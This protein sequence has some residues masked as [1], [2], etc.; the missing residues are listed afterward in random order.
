MKNLLL[1]AAL[2]LMSSFGFTQGFELANHQESFKGTIGETINAPLRFKN[3]SDRPITLIIRKVNSQLGGTQ[4][5]YFC[6]DNNC[7]DQ[8][9]EDYIVK[10]EPGQVLANF[11]IVLEAGLVSGES[12]LS[13][14]A[15]SKSN[16][17][18]SIE[19]NL[20][21]TIEEKP[22]KQNVYSSRFMMLHDVYPNPVVDHAV[23][24]YKILSDQ[25]KAKIVIH[26]L[27]G[28]IVG[29]YSLP[30]MENFVRFKTEDLS[31]GIYFYTLYIDNE[32]VMTR[33]L[34]VKK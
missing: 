7:L 27:L 1:L 32:G 30:S 26:N 14:V 5:N 12:S 17:S 18:N 13:Y 16:P 24:D 9:V 19:F 8:K 23:V 11:Q 15:F 28:N 3:T 6:L 31:A 20:N 4:K 25:I 29:E 34:I 21:F 2:V 33:K 22:E 10:I